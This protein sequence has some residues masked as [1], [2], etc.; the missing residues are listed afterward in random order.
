MVID[1]FPKESIDPNILYEPAGEVDRIPIN[2]GMP[3]LYAVS[4]KRFC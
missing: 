4:F 2:S 1:Q 3:I